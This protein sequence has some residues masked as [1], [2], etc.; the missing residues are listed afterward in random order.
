MSYKEEIVDKD[1]YMEK[2]NIVLSDYKT[3]K[4]ENEFLERCNKAIA[5]L[6]VMATIEELAGN[7]LR[8][9]KLVSKISGIK[10]AIYYYETSITK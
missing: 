2:L 5:E 9:N 6:Q 7:I 3:S 8:L 10:L 4:D 1:G